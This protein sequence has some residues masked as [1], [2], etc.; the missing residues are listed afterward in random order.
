LLLARASSERPAGCP[1]YEGFIDALA[2]LVVKEGIVRV[3]TDTARKGHFLRVQPHSAPQIKLD[4]RAMRAV[5][6]SLVL[7]LIRAGRQMSRSDL[8]RSSQLTKPTVG[9]IVDYLIESGEVR[10]VGMSPMG[11]PGRRARLVE[12][13][14][15]SS[16]Y[17]GL[18]FDSRTVAIAVGDAR[19]AIRCVQCL[20]TP[21]G[22]ARSALESAVNALEPVLAAAGLARSRVKAAGIAV[23]GVVDARGSVV[24]APELGWQSTPLASMLEVYLSVPVVLQS[25]VAASAIAEARQGVGSQRSSYLWIDAGATRALAAVSGGQPVAASGSLRRCQ[26]ILNGSPCDCGL[27]GEHLWLA[28]AQWVD[29]LR[30]ELVV[31][32]SSSGGVPR[33]DVPVLVGA[34]GEEAAARGAALL[35][36]DRVG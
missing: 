17:L 35:A 29:W 32:S 27:S 22:D 26:V 4:T 21:A 30:P 6:R 2:E 11:N 33:L 25:K 8:V 19:G 24:A 16:A 20:P 14:E 31:V 7:N 15:E 28:V 5:N 9:C 18:S 3:V 34:F 23:P 13:N 1:T 10:E 12:L 36:M